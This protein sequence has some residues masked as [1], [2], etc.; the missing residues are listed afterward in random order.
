LGANK[1]KQQPQERRRTQSAKGA[2]DKRI[3][4]VSLANLRNNIM[5]FKASVLP[6]SIV[7]IMTFVIVPLPATA[8]TIDPGVVMASTTIHSSALATTTTAA[9][10]ASYT[11]LSPTLQSQIQE[12]LK[13]SDRLLLNIA[14]PPAI[15]AETTSSSSPPTKQEISLLRE[16]FAAFYGTER[17]P[18]KALDLLNQ[19]VEAWKRQPADE[20]AGL[21]RVRGD[22]FMAIEKPQSAIQDYSTAIELLQQPG[23]ADAADPVELPASL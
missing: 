14:V 9:P 22:C 4:F 12:W 21:Y 18:E 13:G 17:N 3:P 15:A 6:I 7:L 16:A 11:P 19:V 8:F 2:N 1:V 10:A 23:V 5:V 20:R